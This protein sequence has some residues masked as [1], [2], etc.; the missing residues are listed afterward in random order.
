MRETVE[1]LGAVEDRAARLFE[2]LVE[3]FKDDTALSGLLMKLSEDELAHGRIMANILSTPRGDM[4]PFLAVRD[5]AKNGVEAAFSV[6]EKAVEDRLVT[7]E[8]LFDYIIDIESSELNDICLH[9]INTL[10]HCDR[11]FRAEAARIHRHK[12]T[13][14]RFVRSTPGFERYAERLEAL[15][16]VWRE[17]ILIVEDDGFVAEALKDA[18]TGEGTVDTAENGRQALRMIGRNYYAAI[19]SDVDMPVMGG[20]EMRDRAVEVFP[21]IERRMLFL[22]EASNLLSQSLLCARKLRFLVKPSGVNEIRSAVAGMLDG[23]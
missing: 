9:V 6:L 15:P 10:K 17:R 19:L 21:G 5:A 7:R 12:V 3:S 2:R 22:T 18:V 11:S 14:D 13:V 23:M 1:W 4:A 20:I 16:D 8:N